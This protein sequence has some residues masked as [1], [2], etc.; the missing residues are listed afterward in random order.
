MRL[1]FKFL[2]GVETKKTTMKKKY[3]R[4]QILES[5][6]YWQKQLR[7]GNYKKLNESSAWQDKLKLRDF[8][9]QAGNKHP[10]LAV[11]DVG[12]QNGDVWYYNVQDTDSVIY[13]IINNNISNI[14]EEDD[15]I[16]TEYEETIRTEVSN[17]SWREQSDDERSGKGSLWIPI[18]QVTDSIVDKLTGEVIRSLKNGKPA[19]VSFG[20][21]Y[22]IRFEIEYVD[23]DE[24]KDLYKY[25]SIAPWP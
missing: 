14:K 20:G 17:I 5:I 12:A 2:H 22:G 10:L 25:D 6:K 9:S 13:D 11:Y 8:N 18:S 15:N 4:K 16:G 21:E 23:D 1:N 19:I 3:T 7:A 24:L